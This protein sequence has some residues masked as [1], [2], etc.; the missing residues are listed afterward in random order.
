MR[1][2]G[3]NNNI[4]IFLVDNDAFCINVYKKYLN[5]LN[6]FN[7]STFENGADCL[8]NLSKQPDIIFLDYGMEHMNGLEVLKRIK[9]IDPEIPVTFLSGV[10]SIMTAVSA[11]KHGALDYIVKGINDRENIARILEQ[12][13]EKVKVKRNQ[14]EA[15]YIKRLLQEY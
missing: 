6:Y 9:K 1:K 15:D 14:L 13:T 7:I 3:I 8:N 12:V 5:D 10:A 2:K 4:R 11:I